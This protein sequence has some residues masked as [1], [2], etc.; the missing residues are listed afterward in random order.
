[1]SLDQDFVKQRVSELKKVCI[2]GSTTWGTV[3]SKVIGT[4]IIKLDSFNDTVEL[5]VQEETI[6]DKGLIEVINETHENPKYLP[7]CRLPD[8]VVAVSDVVEAAKEAHII[9]FALQSEYITSTCASLYGKIKPTAAGLC[10]TKGLE[11]TEDGNIELFSQIITRYLKIQTSVLMGANLCDEIA[12]E[13]YCEATIGCKDKILAATLKELIETEYFRVSIIDDVD[14]VEVC[15][16]L[17]NIIACGVGFLDGTDSGRS[18][19]ATVI[20]LGLIEMIKFIDLFY[21]ASK[22][23]TFFESCGIADLATCYLAGQNRK[24]GE[25]FVKSKILS[26]SFD[27]SNEGSIE[28]LHTVRK[29]HT[30]LQEK[31]MTYKFPLFTAIYKVFADELSP[32]CFLDNVH[33]NSE[34]NIRLYHLTW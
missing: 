3:I 30:W 11:L 24:Y 15:G 5:F 7:G 21:P 27:E 17:R 4:N 31:D 22:V 9:V 18:A 25:H 26:K 28:G 29:L 20:R 1:M 6:D 19:K 13:L 10:L 8:N 32:F 12:N 14:A 2:V 16:S 34:H 33:G 23:S